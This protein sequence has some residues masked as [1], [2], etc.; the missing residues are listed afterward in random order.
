MYSLEQF[1][2]DT[3]QVYNIGLSQTTELITIAPPDARPGPV[4]PLFFHGHCS[5]LVGNTVYLIGGE[6][7]YTKVLSISIHDGGMSNKSETN[8][9]HYQDGCASFINGNK[10]FIAIAGYTN[11]TEIL[12]VENDVWTQG[13][14]IHTF[15]TFVPPSTSKS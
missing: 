9:M 6:P 11:I 13:I 4:L 3:D 1:S 2:G 15:I 5:V 7:G 14:Q 8:F 12:D 10:S